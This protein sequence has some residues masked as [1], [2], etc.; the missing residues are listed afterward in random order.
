MKKANLISIVNSYTSLSTEL[1][2]FY[3][4]YYSISIK[5]DELKDLCIL[6]EELKSYDIRTKQ[7]FYDGFFLGYTI[8]QIG[9]EFDLLRI[10]EDHIINIEIK[11]TASEGK[12]YR[13]LSRN[14]YYLSFLKK[15]VHSY[16]FITDQ[17]KL[18]RLDDFDSL[19]EVN[20]KELYGILK[21]QKEAE[22]GSLNNLFNPSDYLVSPFNSTNQFILGKYFLT[23]H[24][25]AIKEELIRLS[26]QKAFSLFSI[27][28]KAG[29][30]KTLLTYDIVKHF[31]TEQISTLIVHCGILNDGHWELKNE[32]KWNIIAAK[33]IP[34]FDFS[35]YRVIVIDECQ[36]IYPDQLH[37]II[38]AVRKNNGT[39]IFSYD[40]QQYLRNW[41]S[42]NNISKL[43]EE[44]LTVKT[45][46]LTTKIRTNKEIASFI[47]CLFDKS[48]LHER[49]DFSNVYINYFKNFE[50]SKAY[51]NSQLENGWKAINYT[52]STRAI[53]PYE[54]HK[55][56][57][58]LDNSH[59]VIGQE[60]DNVI[61]VIDQHFF[62]QDD[63]LYYRVN[64]YYNPRQMLFQIVTRTRKKLKLVIVNNPEILEHCLSIV[65]N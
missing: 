22:V 9:K 12:I 16:T 5:D 34:N 48:E 53:L 27:K 11:R 10:G 15:K 3:L 43:L 29:T 50:D 60:F 2:E 40:A 49:Q 54:D 65:K 58:E 32:H 33:Q 35:S 19:A 26:S 20:L 44:D 51:V 39:I 18:Y 31:N 23:T 52:P 59:T 38:N 25:E 63:R 42:T 61:A 45:Y 46:E 41:E 36:R 24:Q 28:G 7:N 62:Y 14:K 37:S 55:I 17:K 8:P 13:Q 21:N 56:A 64:S 4:K 57:S 1:M 30:G 47:K 6:V